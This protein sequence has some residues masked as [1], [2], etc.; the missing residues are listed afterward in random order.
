MTARK[1]SPGGWRRD[2][3]SRLRQSGGGCLPEPSGGTARSS[4]R[5]RHPAR[6]ADTVD[7]GHGGVA[8]VICDRCGRL[9]NRATGNCNVCADHGGAAP[10][11]VATTEAAAGPDGPEG[12]GG[13]RTA[14]APTP[15][16]APPVRGPSRDPGEPPRQDTPPE[17]PRE[18]PAG[19]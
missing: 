12:P 19:S 16:A 11:P 3:G 18:A 5:L 4:F 15:P 17:P 14:P 13:L 6:A 1:V 8:S 9:L 10:P 7:H 2:V